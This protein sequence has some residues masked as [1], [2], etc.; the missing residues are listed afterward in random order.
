MAAVRQVQTRLTLNTPL[1]DIKGIG[2]RYGKSLER[3]GLKTVRD[4][5]YHFPR[6]YED[7]SKKIAIAKLQPGE[8]ASIEGKVIDIQSRSALRRPGLK[9]IEALV[10]DETS[11]VRVVWFNQPYLVQV[12][13]PSARVALAGKV[14]LGRRGLEMRSPAYEKIETS[15]QK[16]ETRSQIHTGRLVP[17][18]P[19]TQ[20]VSSRFLRWLNWRLLSQMNEADFKEWLPHSV[21]ERYKLPE[22]KKALRQVHFPKNL[23]EARHA[24][25]RFAFSQMLLLQIKVLRMRENFRNQAA[26]AFPVKKETL[27]VFLQ[28]LPFRLTR[29]QQ[30]AVFEIL[31]DLSRPFPM[32]RLLDGDVGTG[33]T[34]VAAIAAYQAV[35]CGAQAALMAPTEVLASQHLATFQELFKK[36]SLK[37]ELLTSSRGPREKARLKKQISQGAVDLV[38]GTHALLYEV[39]FKNLGLIIVDEQHRFGVRQRQHLLKANGNDGRFS[40]HYLTMTATPIPRTLALSVYGNLDF[41]IL[42]EFPHA[43][44]QLKAQIISLNQRSWLYELLKKR[45]AQGEQLFVICPVIEESESLPALS[46][47]E[48]YRRFCKYFPDF[49][50]GLVHGQLSSLQ[51]E[52]TLKD[53]ASRKLDILVA[54][55]VVEVGLDIPGASLMVI[56]GAERFGLA[57]LHQLGGRIGRRG[58]EAYLFLLPEQFT[59]TAIRRLKA[60][61]RI[62]DGFKL[63]EADLKIRGPGDF[64][65]ER[66]SGWPDFTFDALKDLKL[67]KTARKV[68]QAILDKSPDLSEFPVLKKKLIEFNQRVHLE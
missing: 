64:L 56:Q 46:V 58:R 36:L 47:K 53:F 23:Q 49:K 52:Q 3:L 54:T 62:K 29:A 68:A 39:G 10:Q 17:I 48:A 16:I 26:P 67:V 63:A 28:S 35:T 51:K 37:I 2:W 25:A 57:Q 38:I 45:L 12:L 31:Q 19:E 1:R 40:P 5:L 32:N 9:I 18:Y 59:A 42:D 6:R 4:A 11:S 44:R 60:F 15:N 13:K 50:V 24:K 8:P 61:T 14:N 20:G 21:I 65:G 33:K 30:I 41:S 66:Q 43:E 55:T 27:R 7:F 22:L 34:V